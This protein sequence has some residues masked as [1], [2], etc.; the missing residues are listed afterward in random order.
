VIVGISSSGQSVY[1]K[2]YNSGIGSNGLTSARH[3][4]LESSYGHHYPETVEPLLEEMRFIPVCINF[5]IR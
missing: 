5:S 1:E 4:V 3:D 2:V